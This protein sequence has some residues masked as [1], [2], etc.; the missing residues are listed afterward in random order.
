[1][2]FKKIDINSFNIDDELFTRVDKFHVLDTYLGKD[3]C[4]RLTLFYIFDSKPITLLSSS[5]IEVEV[6]ERI[7]GRWAISF[8][9]K[10]VNYEDLFISFCNDMVESSRYILNTDEGSQF[11]CNRYI[12]WQKMLNKTS[13]KILSKEE[14]K[15]LI[16]EL[17]FMHD[18]L[19]D[20]YGI[21]ESIFSW[22]GPYGM[23]HDFEIENKWYEVKSISKNATS[24]QISSIEQLDS[25]YAGDLVVYYIEKTT[26]KDAN[27]T[28]LNLL[29][30]LIKDLIQ[31]VEARNYFDQ[32]LLEIGYFESEVYNNYC[33]KIIRKS[34][35]EIDSEFPC[36][37]RKMI[38]LEIVNSKYELALSGIINFIKE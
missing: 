15:G 13:G 35:Y 1:M 9:L 25:P 7:D 5:I 6:G 16:G 33:Y 24:I 37:R 23:I 34:V 31:N 36:I 20:K 8:Y 21:N 12:M 30:N 32:S 4:G 19:F 11:I 14:V 26:T 27:A 3:H 29:I 10:E 22:G 28:N 18:V 17:L 2:S 38:P